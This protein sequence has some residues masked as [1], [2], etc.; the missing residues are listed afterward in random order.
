M[1]ISDEVW[2]AEWKA[3]ESR[4]GQQDT[5]VQARYYEFLNAQMDDGQFVE[6]CAA[7]FV[8]RE[9]FPRPI[10]FLLFRAPRDFLLVMDAA[11]QIH[12]HM[13]KE[14]RDAIMSRVP[15]VARKVADVLGGV[16]V[17]GQSRDDTLRWRTAFMQTY[18]AAVSEQAAT[19]PYVRERVTL[20]KAEQ[21]KAIRDREAMELA[22]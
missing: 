13:E 21:R 7:V 1:A 2:N 18:E 6:A 10:D 20:A 9:F 22:P 19:L 4:W 15:P 16:G 11:R 17:I 14:E 5:E 3:L 12:S 8:S